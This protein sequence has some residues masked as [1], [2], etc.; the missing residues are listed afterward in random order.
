[1]AT[2]VVAMPLLRALNQ[3]AAVVAVPLLLTQPA[4]RSSLAGSSGESVRS[5][6][7]G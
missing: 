4:A 6:C 5:H 7:N 3:R 1:M 2:V